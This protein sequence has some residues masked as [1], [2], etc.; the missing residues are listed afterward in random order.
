MLRAANG[1]VRSRYESCVLFAE[2][3]ETVEMYA[4]LTPLEGAHGALATTFRAVHRTSGELFALR[5]LHACAAPPPPRLAAWRRLDHP[6]I[7]RL[8]RAF[9]TRDFGDH[10]E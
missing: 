9:S 6:N 4:E 5:R 8:H 3:P 2:L 10:C 1:A 7:V